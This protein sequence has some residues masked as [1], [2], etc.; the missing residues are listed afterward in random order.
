MD[1]MHLHD[2]FRQY[3]LGTLGIIFRLLE[4]PASEC[5]RTW[6]H[7][8]HMS[9]DTLI[10]TRTRADEVLSGYNTDMPSTIIW[11]GLASLFFTTA[12]MDFQHLQRPFISNDGIVAVH[13]AVS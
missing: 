1:L 2:W 12:T 5:A 8:A 3:S 10:Q 4:H 11:P 6:Y 9:I 7:I 13:I